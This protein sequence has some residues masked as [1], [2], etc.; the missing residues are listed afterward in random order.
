MGDPEQAAIDEL[1]LKWQ[2]LIIVQQVG[3]LIAKYAWLR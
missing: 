3:D 2:A 1:P